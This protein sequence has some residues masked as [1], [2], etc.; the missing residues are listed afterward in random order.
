M[1]SNT[2]SAPPTIEAPPH[3]FGRYAR[4]CV[5]A[6]VGAAMAFTAFAAVP[7]DAEE[8]P[9]WQDEVLGT[10][11]TNLQPEVVAATFG[12][13][14]NA[15]A[16][17]AGG[18]ASAT[19]T[20]DGTGVA[21][22]VILD[23]GPVV[24]GLP[25]FTVDSSSGDVGVRTAYSESLKYV[26]RKNESQLVKPAP[27]GVE[28]VYVTNTTQMTVGQS[29]VIGSGDDQETATILAIGQAA[30]TTTAF[31]PIAAGATNVEV[32]TTANFPVGAELLIG[33]GAAQQSVTI[34]AVG[35]TSS[36][37]TLAADAAAGATNIKVASVTGR[38]VGD[39][40]DARRRERDGDQRRDCR[41]RGHRARGEPA[42]R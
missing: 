37:T 2:M 17:T 42:G 22:Y 30:V 31:A 7:A 29:L 8:R 26:I 40:L 20:W 36:Q 12:N 21:P 16:L 41:C 1:R 34:T 19:L 25:Y 18:N 11:E 4:T 27:V 3:R 5:A 32:T 10:G 39:V 13:V 35:R 28:T 33:T 14:T 38:Q 15:E 24:G 9:A 23:Y 6:T